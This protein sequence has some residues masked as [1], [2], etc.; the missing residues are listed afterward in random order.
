MSE[1]GVDVA[2]VSVLLVLGTVGFF[3]SWRIPKRDGFEGDRYGPTRGFAKLK[4]C[5]ENVGMPKHLAVSMTE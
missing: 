3:Y 4:T 1:M 5:F 2:I